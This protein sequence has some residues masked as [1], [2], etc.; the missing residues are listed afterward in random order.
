M[1]CGTLLSCQKGEVQLDAN[2][3]SRKSDSEGKV[4]RYKA[5]LVTQGFAQRYGQDHDETFCS[6]LAAKYGLKLHQM[7]VTTAFLNGDLRESIYE[8]TRGLWRRRKR[9]PCL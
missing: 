5:R 6:V 3:H 8:A 2:G 7:D 1:K 9:E 4:E